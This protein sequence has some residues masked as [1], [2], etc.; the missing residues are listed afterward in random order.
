[1]KKNLF[2]LLLFLYFNI[3]YCQTN[4]I[5]DDVN[6]ITVVDHCL[7]EI[8]WEFGLTTF[9]LNV[10]IQ[11][12]PFNDCWTVPP[13]DPL[14]NIIEYYAGT[15]SVGSYIVQCGDDYI[16]RKCFMYRLKVTG[17]TINNLPCITYTEW[18]HHTF[19]MN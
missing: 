19:T 9:N 8:N 14:P 16:P 5:A 3:A 11:I 13:S 7:S 18:K 10:Y 17:R 2:S 6:E 15:D 12:Q 4:C 1:M